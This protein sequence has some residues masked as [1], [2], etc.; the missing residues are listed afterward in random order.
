M[1]VSLLSRQQGSARTIGSSLFRRSSLL[2]LAGVLLLCV[3]FWVASRQHQPMSVRAPGLD[4]F[5]APHADAHRL[6]RLPQ[7]SKVFLLGPSCTEG[8]RRWVQVAL[9]YKPPHA[10]F[11][12]RLDGWVP[13]LGP[14]GAPALEAESLTSQVL[15]LR[16][17][18]K[19]EILSRLRA[20]MRSIRLLRPLRVL[21]PLRADKAFHVLSMFVVSVILF[22]FALLLLRFSAGRALFFSLVATNLLGLSNEI[23]DRFSGRGNFEKA[24]LAAN[25]LGT[26]GLLVAAALWALLTKTGP[27]RSRKASADWHPRRK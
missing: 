11:E 5:Q 26:A 15:A 27:L 13:V 7:S 12:E 25:A 17:F 24:D 6:H 20:L 16:T 9:L 1:S 21:V 19:W 22:C 10:V 4:L 3:S 18:Y 8:G 2:A 14:A 23:V